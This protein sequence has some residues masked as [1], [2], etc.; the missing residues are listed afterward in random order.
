MNSAPDT[1]PGALAAEIDRVARKHERWKGYAADMPPAARD[2]YVESAPG[3]VSL[4]EQGRAAANHPDLATA[5]ALYEQCVSLLAAQEKRVFDVVYE[6]LGEPVKRVEIAER[7]GLS[8]TASTCGVYISKVAA[9]GLI[10]PS[11]PGAVSAADWL[12]F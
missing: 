3:S 8:P 11:G 6:A 7:L 9:Y 10:Q 1:L 2:G 5:E 4:T 12:F